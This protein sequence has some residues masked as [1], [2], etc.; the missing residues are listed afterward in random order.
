M[1]AGLPAGI[2]MGGFLN[3]HDFL[4]HAAQAGQL[5]GVGAVGERFFG[6]VVHFQEN[7]IHAGGDGRSH[8]QGNELWLAAT[9]RALAVA[10]RRRQLHG[11]S[12]VEHH[13]RELAHDGQP[14]HVD[15]EIV[16]AE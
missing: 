7:A 4:Q 5:Q 13:G 15:H 1:K 16:I 2:D 10:G 11:V 9:D 3:G 12:C 8:Q 14:A 6:M